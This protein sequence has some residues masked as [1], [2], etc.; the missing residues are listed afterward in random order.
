MPSPISQSAERSE[1]RNIGPH[2]A[3]DQIEALVE[4]I[5]AVK[6]VVIFGPWRRQHGIAWFH[7]VAAAHLEWIDTELSCQFV[8]RSFHGDQRLRQAIAAESACRHGVGIGGDGIDLLVR[9]V[10]DAQ[11]LADGM[12]QHRAGMI[13][14]G[15]GVGEHVELQRRQSAV[16][17][18]GRLDR[19]AHG[20]ARRGGDELL[21]AG[22]FELDRSPG[23]ECG[24]RQNVLDEHFLLAAEAAADAFAKHPYL[25]GGQIEEIRQRAS[26]QEWH[27]G[28]RP[29]IQ[30]AVGTDPG[31]A[32]MGFQR[33]VLNPLGRERSFVGRPRL[34]PA[35]PRRRRIHHGFPRRCCVARW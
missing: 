29:H 21:F 14:I 24:K 31:E 17:V 30:D 25:V 18:G 19:D 4:P 22:Q 26:R 32:A 15:A 23:L 33:G 20:M 10:I 5:G 28:A 3:L 8:D 34:A 9:A 27:L 13:A 16:L 7:D 11:A 6:H 2:R 35:R 1:L 12:T